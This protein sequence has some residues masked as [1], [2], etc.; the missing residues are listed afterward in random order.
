MR[1]FNRLSASFCASA[2]TPKKYN[3][4]GGL[5]LHVREDGSKQWVFRYQRLKRERAMGLGTLR[6]TS[7]AAARVKADEARRALAEG[8]DPIDQRHAER[9][10]EAA[11]VARL[12]TVRDVAKLYLAKNEAK[13][14]NDKH[15]REWKSSLDRFVHPLIGN[16]AA[17]AVDVAHVLR[18]VEPIWQRIPATAHR[19]LG[20][21]EELIDFA[22]VAGLRSDDANPA[23][24]RGHLDAVL[25][26][27]R[28]IKAKVHHAALPYAEV[29]AFMARLRVEQG[30]ARGRSNLSC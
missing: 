17:D 4:G 6:T 28:R 19:V 25:P 11:A 15:R 9:Q 14:S 21:L 18:V 1:A 24:W 23:R 26:A 3:D 7:L 16:V 8:R 20:R 12:T 10:K 13:W 2:S 29:P 27:P 22:R 5:L 30:A